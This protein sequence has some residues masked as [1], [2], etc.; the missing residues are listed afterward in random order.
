MRGHGEY[1]LNP[2]V[3]IGWTEDLPDTKVSIRSY[4]RHP[5]PHCEIQ[6]TMDS[7][8]GATEQGSALGDLRRSE[9]ERPE[10]TAVC[11]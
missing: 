4:R 6:T 11:A 5:Y 8:D 9:T 1:R 3:G 10:A 7:T 2:T